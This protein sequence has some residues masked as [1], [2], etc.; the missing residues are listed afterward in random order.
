M[1][2]SAQGEESS[3]EEKQFGQTKLDVSFF[4]NPGVYEI[5]DVLNDISYYGETACLL[6]R[7]QAH[8]RQLKNGTH[9]NKRLRDAFTK[10]QNFDGFRFFLVVGGPEF[11]NAEKLRQ[12]QDQLIEE[13]LH[14]CYN[15]TIFEL[16]NLTFSEAVKIRFRF[17]VRFR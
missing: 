15:Q 4:K 3:S 17:R 12:Y 7:F 6:D 11:E 1:N 13:N 8:Y 16:V 5:L 10:Q 2:F 9:P 14:R